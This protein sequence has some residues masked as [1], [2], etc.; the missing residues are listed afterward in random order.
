MAKYY[1]CPNCG[2]S[3]RGVPIVICKE[4]GMVFCFNCSR[5]RTFVGDHRCPSCDSKR[6]KHAGRISS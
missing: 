4:C 1:S 3:K 2:I 6:I 5:Q